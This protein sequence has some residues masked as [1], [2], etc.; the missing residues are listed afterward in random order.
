M[1]RKAFPAISEIKKQTP[2]FLYFLYGST[3]YLLGCLVLILRSEL[4]L[5][6]W[7]W[8]RSGEMLAS[9]TYY[10]LWKLIEPL[11]ICLFVCKYY[12]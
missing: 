4:D 8:D 9:P 1:L 3:S 6:V 10:C 11:W 2:I 12:K 7:E 5:E